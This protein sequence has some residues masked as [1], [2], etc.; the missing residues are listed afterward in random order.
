MKSLRDAGKT[1]YDD[2]NEIEINM[3]IPNKNWIL[4]YGGDDILYK[5][6]L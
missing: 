3:Y 5:F 1:L 6:I 2:Y 4:Q